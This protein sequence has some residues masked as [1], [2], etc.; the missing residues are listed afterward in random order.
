MKYDS[1]T[2][3]EFEL[4][5][6]KEKSP[7]DVTKA[8]E[9]LRGNTYNEILKICRQYGGIHNIKVII[10]TGTPMTDNVVEII[11]IMNLLSDEKISSLSNLQSHM[12]SEDQFTKTFLK[13]NKDGVLV[14]DKSKT[15]ELKSLFR[16]KVSYIAAL[17]SNVVKKIVGNSL[18]FPQLNIF[19]CEMSSFQR[20]S[21][22]RAYTVESSI[23]E[24]QEQGL[25][26]KKKEQ[27][28]FI[29]SQLAS[30]FAFPG[31]TAADP[32]LYGPEGANAHMKKAKNG[33][34]RL[35]D[36]I[37]P[38]GL[39][40][41]AGGQ[42]LTVEEKLEKLK[43]YSCI[44]AE[45]IRNILRNDKKCG[46]VYCEQVAGGGLALFASILKLFGY[47][48]AYSPEKTTTPQKR[49][50]LLTGSASDMIL[51]LVSRFNQEDNF[52]GDYIQIILG[53][54]IVSEGISF[55]NILFEE[56]MS[57]HWNYALL[58]QAIAR[59][60][61]TGSHDAY[62][63]LAN[64]GN[65]KVNVEIRH[66]VALAGTTQQEKENSIQYKM[67]RDAIQ[68]DIS[69]K[70]VERVLK[71]V[72]V[73]C[74]LAYDRNKNYWSKYEDNSREC[75]YM[76]CH[77][78]CEGMDDPLPSNLA[79]HDL[80]KSTYQLYYVENEKFIQDKIVSIF[81]ENLSLTVDE[82]VSRVQAE[83]YTFFEIMATLRKVI[84][85]NIEIK[86]QFGVTCFLREEKNV[87]FLIDS[88]SSADNFL[89]TY[90]TMYPLLTGGT[91]FDQIAE[92]VY[93]NANNIFQIAKKIGMVL[94]KKNGTENADVMLLNLPEQVRELMLEEF[95]YHIKIR[96][97]NFEDNNENPRDARNMKRVGDYILEKYKSMYKR[98]VDLENG[99]DYWVSSL[100]FTSF[101]IMRYIKDDVTS[102]EW[103]IADDRLTEL[104]H[105]Q[106]DNKVFEENAKRMKIGTILDPTDGE[107][108]IQDIEKAAAGATK[109]SGKRC[110]SHKISEL[111]KIL[112]KFD[113]DKPTS[114][115][116]KYNNEYANLSVQECID[117]IN[118]VNNKTKRY[119]KEIL[120]FVD[121]LDGV[122]SESRSDS[123][124][125]ID[126]DS[127]AS[128]RRDAKNLRNAY[129]WLDTFTN[130]TDA[131][132]TIK[133]WSQAKE[134]CQ[135]RPKETTSSKKKQEELFPVNKPISDEPEPIR[136][137]RG[138]PKKILKN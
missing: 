128:V 136:K 20:D 17:E 108:Y 2:D 101:K 129:F 16:G 69:I 60:I 138:R 58:S 83:E 8:R 78:A 79:P 10:L 94:L 117:G 21:Y 6:K 97:S 23:Q 42:T 126:L 90:Y 54:K 85:E 49:F 127:E 104:Y 132:E 27:K 36:Q 50:I 112:I 64:V 3:A 124:S 109:F 32:G 15:K 74:A 40:G 123:D 71:Q 29:N 91:S 44:Y 125:E 56:I 92:N 116:A 93:N 82:L 106:S 88:L 122:V 102:D 63:R 75:D 33:E 70:S 81:Q 131:C 135:T 11:S 110:G 46:F 87:F 62:L 31:K 28:F 52:Q 98:I 72:A 84:D 99:V 39:L 133:A 59:G 45:V 80:D 77:Y 66:Y 65:K 67:Y 76:S 118:L 89:S 9:K 5:L 86:N 37:N 115:V 111:L 38:F 18:D 57:P 1:I 103:K 51:P 19:T 12:I 13:A 68:K 41:S 61:R 24:E 134:I 53:S 4:I 114:Q 107:F 34:F 26:K 22:N 48:R 137:K 47:E 130:Q 35:K 7:L 73:D 95:I 25:K 14:V 55:K 105:A 30:L 113:V 121:E 119:I 43:K 100:L 120:A 96:H